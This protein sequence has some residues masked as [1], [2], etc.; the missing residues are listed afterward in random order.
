MAL[1]RTIPKKY[2]ENYQKGSKK[3]AVKLRNSSPTRSNIFDTSSE[4]QGC[5]GKFAGCFDCTSGWLCLVI[6][7]DVLFLLLAIVLFLLK[8][9][10]DPIEWGW[11]GWLIVDLPFDLIFV[12]TA[13]FILF[14]ACLKKKSP[15]GTSACWD[16]LK[17]HAS[18]YL[19][20]F[21]ALA[22]W[23]VGFI[24]LNR[25]FNADAPRVG[26]DNILNLYGLKFHFS[27]DEYARTSAVPLVTLITN[28]CLLVS[29]V[30][31][32]L[33]AIVILMIVHSDECCKCSCAPVSCD[34]PE[35]D[36]GFRC[37]DYMRDLFTCSDSESESE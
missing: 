4:N 20:I 16:R 36:E 30:V 27:D 31:I 25:G 9:L 33:I 2:Q 13:S 15:N 10:E 7:L 21:I 19:R 6:L 28:L 23:L 14:F 34:C 1:K 37:S 5:C 18:Y 26:S 22:L 12:V 17:T 8:L 32:S 11:L 3:N 24:I 35:D 29:N